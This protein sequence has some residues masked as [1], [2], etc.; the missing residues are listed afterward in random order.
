MTFKSTRT[1]PVSTRSELPPALINLWT[2][3]VGVS[4]SLTTR[5]KIVGSRDALGPAGAAELRELA[6]HA[7]GVRS[8][9]GR[10]LQ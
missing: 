7:P 1:K 6:H 2:G 4:M 5:L 8:S 9:G 10:R 3:T